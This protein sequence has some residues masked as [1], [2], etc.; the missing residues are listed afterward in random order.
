MFVSDEI[1]RI[2]E[3]VRKEFL[4]RQQ[5]FGVDSNQISMPER[6]TGNGA[7]AAQPAGT[8]PAAGPSKEYMA[9]QPSGETFW[10]RNGMWV[11]GGLGL[12]VAGTVAFFILTT[13]DAPSTHTITIDNQTQSK[14]QD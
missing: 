8:K 4:T 14:N 11:A 13:D 1:D 9:A 6:P 7:A 3:K 12:A 2:F 10:K 5:S